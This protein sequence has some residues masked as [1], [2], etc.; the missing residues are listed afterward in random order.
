MKKSVS[1]IGTCNMALLLSFALFACNNNKDGG[2]TVTTDTAGR[3]E[4]M[5]TAGIMGTLD[6]TSVTLN[7]GHA[8]ATFT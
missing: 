7:A 4:K 8:M 6:N 5:D 1:L 2:E 3:M